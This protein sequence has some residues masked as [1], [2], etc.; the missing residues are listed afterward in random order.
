[1][2]SSR[3]DSHLPES[4]FDMRRNPAAVSALCFQR[5]G[6]VRSSYHVPFVLPLLLFLLF[7]IS[8]RAL[9]NLD[10]ELAVEGV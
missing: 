1:M 7:R 2:I 3:S 6:A 9:T 10:R 8:P 4:N 5:I